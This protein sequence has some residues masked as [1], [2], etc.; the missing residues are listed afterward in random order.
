M[1][2]RKCSPFG[3]VFQY[4]FTKPNEAKEHVVLW[5]YN[6]GLVR[7]T[8]FF[9]CRGLPKVCLTNAPVDAS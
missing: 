7:M 1:E 4:V 6:V 5:D 2:L 3:K 8:P 9:K